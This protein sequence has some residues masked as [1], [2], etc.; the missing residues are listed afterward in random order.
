MMTSNISSAIFT[1][2]KLVKIINAAIPLLFFISLL[3][4]I[5]MLSSFLKPQ[6]CRTTQVPAPKRVTTTTS[7][8]WTSVAVWAPTNAVTASSYPRAKWR[9]LATWRRWPEDSKTRLFGE[10]TS[11]MWQHQL[12]SRILK[13]WFIHWQVRRINLS[14]PDP[15]KCLS[16]AM[17]LQLLRWRSDS[18][19]QRRR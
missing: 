16:V 7:T 6:I 12:Q 18:D 14:P 9:S 8:T 1:L 2:C 13:S 4:V 3:I 5:W 19:I 11:T 15:Y 17:T 10:K